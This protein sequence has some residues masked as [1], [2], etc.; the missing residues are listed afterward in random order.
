MSDEQVKELND[1]LLTLSGDLTATKALADSQ[2]EA[3]KQASDQIAEMRR[4][5]RRKRFTDEV[6]GVSDA[7][8]TAWAG[9]IDKNVGVLETLADAVG[10]DSE[11]FRDFVTQQRAL[12][13]QVRKS[14]LFTEIG[15]SQSGG[16]T[17]AWD[18][19]EV[20]AHKIAADEKVTFA[21]AVDLV[22]QRNPTL[23]AEYRTEQRRAAKEA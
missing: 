4:D 10:E 12:A 5:E 6:R 22:T 16:T 14:G 18:R 9:A 8:G 23:Y 1:K 21:K 15:S 11:T 3:L 20:E 19:I 2:A 17:S 7:S 13:E